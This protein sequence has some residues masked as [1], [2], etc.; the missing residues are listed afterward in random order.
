MS[1]SEWVGTDRGRGN[2]PTYT[3][4]L[5]FCKALI[6]S[7]LCISHHIGLR[8]WSVWNFTASVSILKLD[9]Y[10]RISIFSDLVT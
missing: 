10:K 1:N 7:S 9:N 5:C 2:A 3:T 4:I 6:N 8:C